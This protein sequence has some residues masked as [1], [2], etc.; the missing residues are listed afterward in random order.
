MDPSSDIHGLLN[1]AYFYL[2]FRPRT[3]AEVRTYLLKKIKNRF[4]SETH[5][6]LVLQKLEE[7]GFI[8]DKEFVVWFVRGRTNAKQ[9]SEFIL[10][11]ELVRFGVAKETINA[12]FEEHELDEDHL[13][14]AALEGKWRRFSEFDK[15]ER[16]EKAAS[17]L[18]RRG[19]SFDLIK[20]TIEKMEEKE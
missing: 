13:A 15:K 3:R 12:Y 9:K 4:W 2:K 11:Q 18:S 17:F 14:E 16:F 1:L 8:N 6:E 20:K 19:F 7:Q 5:V 10:R